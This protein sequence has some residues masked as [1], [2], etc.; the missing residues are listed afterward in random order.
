[1]DV[2]PGLQCPNLQVMAES[3][4]RWGTIERLYHSALARSVNERAAFLAEACAGD[5]QLRREIESL[6]AQ[7]MSGHGGLTG[8]AVVAAAG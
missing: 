5:E 1:M 7:D 4:T 2:R 6:L 3:P 8:G